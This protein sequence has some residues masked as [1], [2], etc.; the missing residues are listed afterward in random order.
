MIRR[1]ALL[2]PAGLGLALGAFGT[3][4]AAPALADVSHASAGDLSATLTSTPVTRFPPKTELRIVRGGVTGFDGPLVHKG[5]AD[6]LMGPKGSL[7]IHDL[8][9]D[10]EPE[11]VV[12]GYSGGAH[13]CTIGL[14]YRWD[15]ASQSYLVAT[16]EFGD[17]GFRVRDLDG[18]GIPELETE[19]DAFAYAFTSYAASLRP[20]QVI[21][22][23]AG[24]F[25]DVTKQ[26]AFRPA[27]RRHA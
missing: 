22:Y 19:D 21:A 2:A 27:I 7:S 6:C 4:G 13:C 12:A 25:A 11:V 17:P 1:A 15:P 23:R 3:L 24:A 10:G 20:L 8:D 5:C 14:V 16:H 18:D 26:R 9:G